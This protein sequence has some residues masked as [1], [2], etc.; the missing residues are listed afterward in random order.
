MLE[1]G[2][3]EVQWGVAGT[4]S[5]YDVWQSSEL[6]CFPASKSHL[7]LGTLDPG[8][9]KKAVKAMKSKTQEPMNL[10]CQQLSYVTSLFWVL[11]A[12]SLKWE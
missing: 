9:R 10:G 11:V 3:G 8:L 4:H 5:G 12:P 2:L 6:H 7:E 1:V